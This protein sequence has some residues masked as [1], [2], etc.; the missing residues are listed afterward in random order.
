MHFHGE[1][2]WLFVINSTERNVTVEL[3]FQDERTKMMTPL[4]NTPPAAEAAV[5]I[6]ESKA[7][8]SCGPRTVQV[9]RLL[10]APGSSAA[11]RTGTAPRK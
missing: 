3:G 9:W 11:A 8:V 2:A 1:L 4:L 7:C 6:R 10:S 5:Q